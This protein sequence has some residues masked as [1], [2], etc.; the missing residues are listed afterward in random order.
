M[1]DLIDAMEQTLANPNFVIESP[2]EPAMELNYRFFIG[3]QVGDKW[4]CVV[5][6]YS[7][8]DAF[9]VTA[10]LTNRVKKGRRIWPNQ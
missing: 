8:N 5:V 10:Y 4:L 6:K 9:V 2:I 1:V 7:V 3:T